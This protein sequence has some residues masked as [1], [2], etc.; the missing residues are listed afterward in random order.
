LIC[1]IF[2]FCIEGASW[3]VDEH[4][5]HRLSLILHHPLI[6]HTHT[7]RFVHKYIPRKS[8]PVPLLLWASSSYPSPSFQKASIIG[9]RLLSYLHRHI[10]GSSLVWSGIK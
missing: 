7:H 3:W 5:A 6:I 4:G 1:S 2:N 8:C 10:Q 9:Q